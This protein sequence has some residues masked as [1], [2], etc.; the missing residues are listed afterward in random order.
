MKYRIREIR[1]E[2][3]LTQEELS[4][5]SG[6]SRA[7][8]WAL[9]RGENKVTTTKTLLNIADALGVPLDDLFLAQVAK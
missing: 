2:V 6:V 8:I 1:E 9:E 3:G 5:K 7:T 4:A